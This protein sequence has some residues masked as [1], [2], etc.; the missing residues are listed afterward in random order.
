[1]RL[2]LENEALTPELITKI[3]NIYSEQHALEQ[4]MLDYYL[5]ENDIKNRT[6][7]DPTRVNNKISH[8]FANYI[9]QSHVGYFLGNPITYKSDIDVLQDI[10]DYNDEQAENLE[11][12]KNLAVYGSAYELLWLD[13]FANIRF[14]ILDNRQTIPIYDNSLEQNLIYLIRHYTRTDLLTSEQKSTVIVYTDKKILTYTGNAFYDSLKLINE[15][16][17]Y[18]QDVPAIC[19]L[20]NAEQ[21]SDF[22]KVI[23]LINAYDT[24]A[25]N[26]LNDSDAFA[27]SYLVFT[28]CLVDEEDLLSMKNSKTI[29]LDNEADV[30]YLTKDANSTE[31]ESLK[32]TLFDNIF[33]LSST[34]NMLD[35]NFSQNSSGVALKYKCLALENLT[36]IKERFFRKG[37]TRR[38]ELICNI[39]AVKGSNYDFRDV[40]M[41][42]TRNLP[43]DLDNLAETVNKLNGIVSDETLLSLLPFVENIDD[44]LDKI[45]GDMF[46]SK[47]AQKD[48]PPRDKQLEE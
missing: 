1:M 39:L 34:P 23:D 27:N 3:I 6:F 43:L 17:H 48:Y 36:S 40:D 8:A 38:I 7:T 12:A 14:N 26:R 13:E 45:G 19:Y 21:T 22:A 30:K 10:F 9:V 31:N 47:E 41:I 15:E 46:D 33:L 4:K 32:N 29:L 18:F 35:E 44:E 5:N 16:L 20:N 2:T 11:L 25:S 42:F 37:L 28:N 24:L